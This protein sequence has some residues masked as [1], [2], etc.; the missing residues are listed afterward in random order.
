MKKTILILLLFVGMGSAGDFPLKEMGMSLLLPGLGQ[1][2]SGNGKKALIFTG[3]EAGIWLGY[4]GFSL[5]GHNLTEDYKIYGM[6]HAGAD[7]HTKSEDYWKA[8]ELYFSREDYLEYMRRVARSLY[9]DDIEAQER[10][11]EAHAVKGN[12]EWKTKD[13][14]FSFQDLIKGSR[15]A[16]T[17]ARLMVFAAVLNRIASAIDI[18]LYYKTEGKDIGFLKGV[19]LRSTMIDPET[20][21]LGINAH[22]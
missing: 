1:W 8:V 5:Q 9:P 2:Y 21:F 3:I 12:W 4:A 14:W 10:Y 11:V 17:R 19:R 15:I 6:V 16:Y 7:P 13:E 22:F 20:I 18:L